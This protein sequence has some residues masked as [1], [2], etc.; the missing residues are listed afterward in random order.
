[1]KKFFIF[2]VMA[3]PLVFAGC[4]SD[5]DEEEGDELRFIQVKLQTEDESSALTALYYRYSENITSTHFVYY[6]SFR[7]HWAF[8][9]TTTDDTIHPLSGEYGIEMSDWNDGLLVHTYYLDS[10][11]IEGWGSGTFAV[12]VK[13]DG[14]TFH[15][16]FKAN[17]SK[18]V[19]AN[20]DSDTETI[21]WKVEN[22][23]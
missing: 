14:N 9:G 17:Q 22:Y 5:S 20:Y 15:H 18:V 16:K 2:L 13:V 1:M 21:T 6:S 8:A 4:S 11:D 23:K 3:L 19:Y 7:K 10:Y 12:S